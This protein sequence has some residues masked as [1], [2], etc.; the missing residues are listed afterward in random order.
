LCAA[1]P[2][3]PMVIVV[4]E[5]LVVWLMDPMADDGPLGLEEVVH[6]PAWMSQAACRGEPVGTFFVERGGNTARARARDLCSRCPVM[7][8]CLSYADADD[9]LD[10]WWGGTSGRARRRL[11]A[12]A[13]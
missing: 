3:L 8:E 1:V 4:S 11:R 12:R 13:S 9:Q 2:S 5:E 6:R 7:G 10:G